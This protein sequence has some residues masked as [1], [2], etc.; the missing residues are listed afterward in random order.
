MALNVSSNNQGGGGVVYYLDYL[1][2]GGETQIPSA[3]DPNLKKASYVLVFMEGN[4]LT[5]GSASDEYQDTSA[6]GYITFNFPAPVDNR[7]TI[8]GFGSGGVNEIIQSDNVINTK[9]TQPQTN[10]QL[11]ALYPNSVPSFIVF[12]P[13]IVG[14]GLAYVYLGSGLWSSSMLTLN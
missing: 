5:S 12:C 10:A 14:G 2:T 9:I 6:S 11:N 13:N 8:V 7:F 3:P 4:K 1:S